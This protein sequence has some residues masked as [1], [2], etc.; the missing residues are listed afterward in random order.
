MFIV[1]LKDGKTLTEK[2]CLWNDVPDGIV[3]LQL[4]LPVFFKIKDAKTGVIKDAPA[5]TVTLGTFDEYFFDNEAVA[6]AMV[7]SD[8]N[9]SIGKQKG[10]LIA[11]I[12]GGIDRKKEQVVQIR[13]DRFCN[14]SVSTMPL[15]DLKRDVKTIKKGK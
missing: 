4:S 7:S 10:K 14:V 2:D 1:H 13:V 9:I 15:S 12:I 8:G 5:P 3:N 6:V 11:Q